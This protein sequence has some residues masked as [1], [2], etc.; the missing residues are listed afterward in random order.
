MFN[1]HDV[2]VLLRE[3]YA[4]NSLRKWL[5]VVGLVLAGVIAALFV[6]FVLTR[7]LARLTAHT[8]TKL[9]D[10]LV[11]ATSMPLAFLTFFAFAHAALHVPRLP[12]RLHE[13]VLDANAVAMALITAL[14]VWRT[15]DVLFDELMTPWAQRHEPPINEQVVAIA[16]AASK[17]TAVA[18]LAVTALHRAGFDVVSVITGLGIGGVAVAFAAQETL[19]NILG[20]LQ[21]MT[22]QPFVVGDVIRIDNDYSGRVLRMGLRSTRLI[23]TAGVQIIVPNKKIAAAVLQNFSHPNGLVKD[24]T[25]QLDRLLTAEQLRQAKTI[26]EEVLRDDPR[27]AG[28]FSVSLSGYGDWSSNLRVIY[29]VAK[30]QD[31][32]ATGHDVLLAVRERLAAAGIGLAVPSVVQ[33]A[34]KA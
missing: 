14:L 4:G 9:D 33:A 5:V 3:H 30:L 15:L 7:L 19:G 11:A 21:I 17:W 22:D 20:A 6:R 2:N 34:L 12:D 24:V 26:A 31:A 10:R 16:R 1:W 8:E 25:F 23:T 28:D 27:I 18:F 29:C 32:T 13:M